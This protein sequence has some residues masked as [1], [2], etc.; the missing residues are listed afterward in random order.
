MLYVALPGLAQTR[1]W[2]RPKEPLV[3]CGLV[4]LVVAIVCYSVSRGLM[5]LP[6]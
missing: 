3:D 1:P 4:R 5:R 6:A 2:E